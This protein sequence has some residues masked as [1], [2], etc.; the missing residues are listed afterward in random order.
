MTTFRTA[1]AAGLIFLLVACG[2]TPAPTAAPAEPA[3]A[4]KSAAG[5]PAPP[6]AK[7]VEPSPGANPVAE[8]AGTER[9]APKGIVKDIVLPAEATAA[10]ATGTPWKFQEGSHFR[11]LTSAEGTSSSPT[12]IE[13]AEVFWYGCPHC[14]NLDPVLADW[15]K[16]LPNDVAFVRLPVMWNATNEVHARIFYTA[17]AL[18][19]VDQM[20]PA[21]FR[22]IHVDNK[23]LTDEQEIQKF[24]AQFGVSAEDFNKTFHSFAVDS[25]LQR[26][27][28]LTARYKVA[29]V[30]LL[31]VN[32]KYAAN[33][34][35]IHSHED[36]LAVTDELIARERQ[37]N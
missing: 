3:A 22:A 19:K 12:K 8:S 30:P 18:G 10:P 14:Y 6:E 29:G 36:M 37:R 23:P 25:Q 24:F 20:H 5:T 13:V 16:K 32:G 9:E 2:K 11:V 28:N 31:I 33:G 17:Q 1:V 15:V 7:S 27:R 26:A 34:P 35:E 4:A 21:I